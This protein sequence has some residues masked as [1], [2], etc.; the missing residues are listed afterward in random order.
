MR[1]LRFRGCSVYPKPHG[2]H[3]AEP[4]SEPGLGAQ[5]PF[6]AVAMGSCVAPCEIQPHGIVGESRDRRSLADCG[7]QCPAGALLS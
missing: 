5:E 1:S 7:G 4:G 6:F 3:V 2:K